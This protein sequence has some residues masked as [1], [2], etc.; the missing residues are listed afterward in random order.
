MITAKQSEVK[1]PDR[2]DTPDEVFG[3]D[4]LYRWVSQG[5]SLHTI[6]P[7]V[8]K[9]D[10]TLQIQTRWVGAD[11]FIPEFYSANDNE[12]WEFGEE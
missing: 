9:N 4:G 2:E 11:K 5:S 3:L 1:R 7:D 8:N 12:R 6:Q 10:Y